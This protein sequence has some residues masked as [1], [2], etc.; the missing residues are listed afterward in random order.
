M[1]VGAAVGFAERVGWNVHGRDSREGRRA[2]G[3]VISLAD[4]EVIGRLGRIRA[5]RDALHS[6]DHFVGT[7]SPRHVE[8]ADAVPGR[9]DEVGRDE[10]AAAEADARRERRLHENAHHL[11]M[12]GVE[13]AADDG[14]M[15]RCRLEGP[16][17]HTASSQ[18]EREEEELPVCCRREDHP[19]DLC[20]R[21]T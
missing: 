17:L 6:A 13:D 19:P 21:R 7:R 5:G 16:L 18:P 20:K 15:E 4:R 8:A 14:L 11:A 10:E 3:D 9:H 1:D 12:R 2:D